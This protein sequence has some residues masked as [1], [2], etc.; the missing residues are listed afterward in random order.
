VRT[1]LRQLRKGRLPAS[2]VT[3]EWM[4]L[5]SS[6]AEREYIIDSLEVL[7][8]PRG[9]IQHYRYHL[10]Y[11]HPDLR[12]KF[13]ANPRDLVGQHV[14]VSYLCQEQYLEEDKARWRAVETYPIRLG[15]VVDVHKTGRIAHFHFEVGEYVDYSHGYPNIVSR[16]QVALGGKMPP[17]SYA[18]LAPPLEGFAASGDR[19]PEAFQAI[20]DAF[21]PHHL[22]TIR[23]K[24][25]SASHTARPDVEI[26]QY[27]PVF[28]QVVGVYRIQRDDDGGQV[29]LVA[30][31]PTRVEGIRDRAYR[32]DEE[33]LHVVRVNTYQPKWSAVHRVGI[34]I[35]AT[36]DERLF[37]NP[38]TGERTVGSRYDSHEFMLAPKPTERSVW[39]FLGL[40]ARVPTDHAEVLV[41]LKAFW[42]Q[43]LPRVS[44]RRLQTL[45]DILGQLGVAILP[46]SVAMWARNAEPILVSWSGWFVLGLFLTSL[47]YF[48]GP[49]R[50]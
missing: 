48:R 35:A 38:G 1:L 6:N 36:V 12:G 27:D 46:L 34:A 5:F 13:D 11:L 22:R 9:A 25:A 18:C 2:N 50:L 4:Y 23:L 47:K 8:L 29:S 32:L 14:L 19:D 3:N 7:A 20:V 31:K 42:V 39:T 45:V 16:M 26:V 49:L 17:A 44:R 30:L 28:I 21:D 15:L 24:K 40:T 37:S 41:P 43:I 10:Q 33:D